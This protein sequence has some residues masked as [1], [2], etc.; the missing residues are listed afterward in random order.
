MAEQPPIDLIERKAAVPLKAALEVP[1][2]RRA[3]VGREEPIR[4]A[5]QRPFAKG[6]YAGAPADRA[7][8]LRLGG[9]W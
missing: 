1:P 4:T 5:R 3:E 7:I 9:S 8:V 2:S 6:A